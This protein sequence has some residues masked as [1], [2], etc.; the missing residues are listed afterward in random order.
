MKVTIA[1]VSK[2]FG[3][4]RALHDV[5]LEIADGEL[6]FLLGPS[7]CG[8][9]TL[10]RC[11]GGFESVSSGQIM[12]N[13][14]DV[15]SRPANERNT[16]MVFQGYALWPHMTVAEN[17]AFGLE[18]RKVPKD[19]RERRVREALQ[20]VQIEHLRQRKPNELS[21]GQQQRVALAR[22]LVVEPGC[23]LLDEPLANLDAKL[24]R[25][26]R[27]EIRRLCKDSGLTG[28][29]V[30]HDRQEALSMADRVA[31]LKDG[32]VEQVA[33]P[34]DLYRRPAS[35]FI[36]NFIGETNFVSG[37]IKERSAT[38]VLVETPCGLIRSSL[39]PEWAREGQDV[40]LSLRPEALSI[41]E[42]GDNTLSAVL[43]ESTYLGEIANHVAEV[44][45]G[46]ELSFCELNPVSGGRAGEQVTL[47]VR[48]S[49]VVVLPPSAER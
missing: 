41:G 34:Q 35:A 36:A 37:T 22:T 39:S 17:V 45:G 23:L 47:S 25:D 13:G 2:F 6:F 16:A 11:I 3:Q 15:A 38:G 42:G 33:T 5:N 49:D 40:L 14:E 10:L 21:G 43:R 7:G 48:A 31:V 12:L 44:A 46:V 27:R 24:R 8:K 29:Y 20:R 4:V 32:V 26:M 9:T 1:G 28:I 19:E 18:M 30:T